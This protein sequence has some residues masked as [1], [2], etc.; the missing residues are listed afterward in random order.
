MT[1][2]IDLAQ[3]IVLMAALQQYIIGAETLADKAA[4]AGITVARGAD[5]GIDTAKEL[6]EEVTKLKYRG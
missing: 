2:E 5:S 4:A 3:K 1:L 6:L